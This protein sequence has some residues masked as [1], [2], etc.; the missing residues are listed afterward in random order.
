[1]GDLNKAEPLPWP[2]LCF[3]DVTGTMGSSDS[4]SARGQFHHF[5]LICLC[6]TAY[7]VQ[8]KVSPVPDHTLDTCRF[9]YTV[10][11]FDSAR[12]SSSC[13][14]WSSPICPGS[15]SHL[16]TCVAF[17]TIRQNSLHVTTCILASTLLELHHP[18]AS[19][20]PF[21]LRMGIGYWGFLAITPSGLSPAVWSSL[22]G[23]TTKQKSLGYFPDSRVLDN[24]NYRPCD[25]S[26]H[27]TLSSLI[28]LLKYLILIII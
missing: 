4:F 8:R 9:L 11:F 27:P 21:L 25:H 10:G 28:V 14:P 1:M 13:L 26:C 2:C 20:A 23:R 19:H 22:S 6:S 15:T 12:P 18:P 16:S 3:H 7:A 5:G 24:Y 17:L